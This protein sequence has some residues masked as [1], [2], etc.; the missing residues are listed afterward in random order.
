MSLPP[1]LTTRKTVGHPTPRIDAIERATGK[2]TYT[3][4][5]HLPGMLY[6]RLLRSTH[7]H[8]QIRQID[9]SKAL[10]LPGVKSILT[11][12]HCV[13]VWGSGSVSGGRQYVDEVKKI[14]RQRRYA[15]NNPVRFFGEPV[16][17]VAAINRHI[18]EEALRLITVDYEVLPCVLDPEEALKPNAAQ[19]WPEGNLA[20]NAKNEAKPTGL[21]RGDIKV[22]FAAS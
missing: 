11:H 3:G 4:D 7:A 2:A 19:I 15:F 8:A 20:L 6:A 9:V 12:E 16:A 1:T 18:A 10:A 17:A 21:K 22:G 13:V 5:V 14:T